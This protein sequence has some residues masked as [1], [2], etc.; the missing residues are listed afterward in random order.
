MPNRVIIIFNNI[1]KIIKLYKNDLNF[2][3][4]NIRV[5]SEFLTYKLS[6]N[7]YNKLI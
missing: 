4:Y 5:L 6:F 3:I 2:N 1:Y 7:I